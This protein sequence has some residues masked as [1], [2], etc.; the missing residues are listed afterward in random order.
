[1]ER[2][3]SEQAGA[4]PAPEAVEGVGDPRIRDGWT[5]PRRA[6]LPRPT[7][8]PAAMA[9]G[10]VFILWGFTT[11]LIITGIGLAVFAVS[12]AGWIREVQRES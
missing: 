4:D 3:I 5:R 7:Y 6:T 1:M 2:E 12:L 8:W 11:T 10:I 9:F